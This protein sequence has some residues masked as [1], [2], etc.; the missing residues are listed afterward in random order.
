MTCPRGA[1]AVFGA[2]LTLPCAARAAQVVTELMKVHGVGK[3]TAMEWYTRGIRSVDDALEAGVMNETQKLASRFW[4][5][6]DER[7]PRA[8]VEEIA[9]AVRGALDSLLVADGYPNHAA[10]LHSV[11]EARPCGSYRRGK[12]S[13][14]DVDVLITRRD[15]R[16]WQ[17]LLGKVLRSL[18]FGVVDKEKGKAFFSRAYPREFEDTEALT[19]LART[20]TGAGFDVNAS[21]AVGATD[22]GVKRLRL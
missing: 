3:V 8:E 17:N 20:A 16:A 19:F 7:I 6:L 14:G 2:T 18:D 11:I 1:A 9:R 15:G 5:D 4:R 10:K 21:G 12:P 13:S 22:P